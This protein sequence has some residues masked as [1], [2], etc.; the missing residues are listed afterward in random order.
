MSSMLRATRTVTPAPDAGRVAAIRNTL[1]LDDV[2]S[3]AG[4]GVQARR[5]VLACLE[6]AI[7][8]GETEL[9]DCVELL[10]RLRGRMAGLDP[11]ALASPGGLAGLFSTRGGRLERF[12]DRFVEAVRALAS[13]SAEIRPLLA[14]VETRGQTLDAVHDR[15]RAVIQEIDACLE[16]GRARRAEAGD[17]EA[18]TVLDQ[19]LADLGALRGAALA[20]LP[21]LRMAQN[22]DGFGAEAARAAIRAAVVWRDEWGEALG[23]ERRRRIRPDLVWLNQA[24]QDADEALARAEVALSTARAR[25]AGAGDRLR[26]AAEAARR[27]P[28]PASPPA[29]E[30]VQATS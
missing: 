13:T 1:T 22:A 29:T 26:Q 5:D 30:S 3:V 28:Q 4:F 12:R 15:L 6:Q 21:V 24:R 8:A 23:M 16:A 9:N 18:A 14:R 7:E 17:G 2:Q 10:A 25:R 11:A 20:Q 27:E 19:R